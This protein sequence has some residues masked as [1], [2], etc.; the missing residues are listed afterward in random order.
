MGRGGGARGANVIC[1]H[2]AVVGDEWESFGIAGLHEG[3][4]HRKVWLWQ[5]SVAARSLSL[6][7]VGGGSV[8]KQRGDYGIERSLNAFFSPRLVSFS[9][10]S[11][12]VSLF[13]C[14]FFNAFFFSLTR[15]LLTLC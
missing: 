1:A 15:T 3:C 4:P 13:L 5:S 12:S 7:C 10:L 9:Q 14:V 2:S 8:S 6:W 11:L